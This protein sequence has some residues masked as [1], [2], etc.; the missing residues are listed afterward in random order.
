MYAGNDFSDMSPND[1]RVLTFD[2][3]NDVDAAETITS[4][5]WTCELHPDMDP[6]VDTDLAGHIQGSPSISGSKVSQLV[7]D[8]KAGVVYRIRCMAVS[9]N[10]PHI[11]LYAH[12]RCHAVQ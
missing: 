5:V 11:E 12:L 4:A 6:S 1:D 7:G 3:V 2:F 10:Q 9:A 8:L